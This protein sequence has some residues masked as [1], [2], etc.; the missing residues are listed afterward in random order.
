MKSNLCLLILLSLAIASCTADTN[1]LPQGECIVPE[2]LGDGFEVTES[3]WILTNIF[4]DGVNRELVFENAEG[5]S[6][7]TIRKPGRQFNDLV[8]GPRATLT[9]EI[10]RPTLLD[11]TGDKVAEIIWPTKFENSYQIYII[12]VLGGP[13]V[14]YLP[15]TPI[16]QFEVRENAKQYTLWISR[17]IDVFKNLRIPWKIQGKRLV[18]NPFQPQG[19]YA[20][21]F[22]GENRHTPITMFWSRFFDD[23]L[24]LSDEEELKAM[25]S[26]KAFGG[27]AKL[28][29]CYICWDDAARANEGDNVFK[30]SFTDPSQNESATESAMLAHK[31]NLELLKGNIQKAFDLAK[32]SMEANPEASNQLADEILTYV[33]K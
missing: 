12:G 16:T 3:G 11:L 18:P 22:V 33:S 9:D 31:A 7:L 20:P 29:Y 25:F 32:A 13:I 26:S 30:Q 19:S 24:D 15:E 17:P 2:F 23:S 10:V 28:L 27:D 5:K 6:S 14:E 1:A 4:G 8:I 21:Q